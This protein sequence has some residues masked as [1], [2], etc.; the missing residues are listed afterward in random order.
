MPVLNESFDEDE[1]EFQKLHETPSCFIVIGKPVSATSYRFTLN[2]NVDGKC[3]LLTVYRTSSIIAQVCLKI[4][5]PL[6]LN[7]QTQLF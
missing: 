3:K 6:V 7:N 2:S 1:A 5:N 4:I